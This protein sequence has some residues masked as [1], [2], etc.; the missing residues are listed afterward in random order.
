M[1]EPDVEVIEKIKELRKQALFLDAWE[2]LKPYSPPE[3][4]TNAEHRL[5]GARLLRH[6]GADAR[7]QKILLKLWR[8]KATRHVAR[9]AIRRGSADNVCVIMV[10]LSDITKNTKA[11]VQK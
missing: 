8:D 3:E 9:E 7:E 5:V 1:R 2:L 10:W 4:W 11:P 6:L